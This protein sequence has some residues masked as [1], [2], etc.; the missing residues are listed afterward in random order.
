[1][2]ALLL[3]L[4]IIVVGALLLVV[5]LV[6]GVWWHQERIAYQPPAESPTPP[7]DVSRIEYVAG[8]GQRL[9]GY[10]IDPAATAAGLLVAFHG[11]ADLATWQ[12]PWAREVARHTGWSVLLAEYRGYGGLTGAPTYAAVQQD[13]R[14]AWRA[15]QDIA[16]ARLVSP[17]RSFALFG[18]SLGSAVAMELAA[19]I[20]AT[21]PRA[22]TAVLLQSPFTTA[23]E[24]A[25][26]VSTRPVQVLWKL[27]SRVHYDSRARLDEIDAPI[28]VSHGERDWLVPVAM[29]REL[30]ARSRT[31]G[32]LLIVRDAGH[33]DVADVGGDAYWRWMSGALT[34]RERDPSVSESESKVRTGTSG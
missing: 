9:Y 11:N 24:M 13:A 33:N 2:N 3:T 19:E 8:D 6:G 1:M 30:F 10:V 12:I 21:Q 17:A 28:W 23:R 26:I 29:G 22:I 15:A 20:R 34:A 27:I 31:P 18:H 14:A 7:P 4:A 16:R 32:E 25:R 5:A